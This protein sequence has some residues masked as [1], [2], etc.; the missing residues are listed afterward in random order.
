VVWD[1][2]R[3]ATRALPTA[4]AGATDPVRRQAAEGSAESPHIIRYAS[5]HM[6]MPP[7]SP[8]PGGDST[9]RRTLI[10]LLVATGFGLALLFIY[11]IRQVLVWMLVATLLAV[12]LD[13]AVRWLIRHRWHRGLAALFVTLV[14]LL[15]LIGI[16]AALASPLVSEAKGLI[17]HFPHY[18]R[19]VFSGHSP[20]ASLDQRFHIVDRVHSLSPS[21]VW[22]VVSGGGVSILHALSKGAT[23]IVSTITTLTLMIMLLIE[24]PRWWRAL[25]GLFPERR[26]A[27]V[28]RIGGRMAHGVGGYVRG[29]LL[30]SVIAAALAYAALVI[31][32]IPYAVPLALTVGVLDIIPLVGATIGAV[33]CVLVAFAAGW[34]PAVVLVIYFVIYQMAENH[35]V[36]PIVYSR[37]VKLSPL[38]VLLA[39][40]IGAV[41]AGIL[42]VL[43]AIPLASAVSILI[44]EIRTQ[45]AADRAPAPAIVGGG[46]GGETGMPAQEPAPEAPPTD[47]KQA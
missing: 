25:V 8:A 6:N 42:G 35:F 30:I 24:G 1:D 4:Y 17:E 2:T 23:L 20:L 46:E 47:P 7:L 19:D 33:V 3:A 12:A 14:A 29:N 27:M 40:L 39:S 10:V 37:T 36:Q 38:V 34:L 45:R 44:E 18:V 5:A 26:R 43:V 21:T 16:F 31:L 28:D 22:K 13:P 15:V 11:D 32:G 9:A 41:M